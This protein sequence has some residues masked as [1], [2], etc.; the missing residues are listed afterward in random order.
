MENNHD[1]RAT[2]SQP[3]EALTLDEYIEREALKDAFWS[4][5]ENCLSEDDIADLI[6]DMPAADV[7]PVVRCKDCIN[8]D[9]CSI[10]DA[11]KVSRIDLGKAFCCVGKRED[12][13]DN[14]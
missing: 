12:G 10:E 4:A 11:F 2:L 8:H 13:D 6:D 7:A 14:G 9:S 5:C 1:I 3:N